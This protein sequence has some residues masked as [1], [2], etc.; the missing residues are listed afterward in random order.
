M[1]IK[2]DVKTF[3]NFYCTSDWAYECWA[4]KYNLT[5]KGLFVLYS[6]HEYPEDCTQEKICR[7]NSLSKQTVNNILN[8]FEKSGYVRRIASKK[9]KR[10]KY[11]ELTEEGTVYAEGLLNEL[12]QAEMRA[13]SKMTEAQR[14]AMGETFDLLLANLIEELA[15]DGE[16]PF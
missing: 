13:M 1:S 14:K 9:D 16:G 5:S 15:V 11:I 7:L 4:K 10:K 3:Y 8:K 12:L 2:D 6:I